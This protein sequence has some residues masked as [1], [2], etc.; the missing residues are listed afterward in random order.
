MQQYLTSHDV[1]NT[2]RMVRTL[3]RGSIV[4]VE[5]DTDLRVYERLVDSGNC[6]LI[7]AFGKHNALAAIRDL[8]VSSFRG[9]AAIVDSDFWLLDSVAPPGNN[10]LVTDS[11][12][13]ESMI[14]SSPA[15]DRVTGELVSRGRFARLGMRIRD[16]L[17]TCALPLGYFR[18]L[19][20]PTK[21][22]VPLRFKEVPPGSFLSRGTL[23]PDVHRMVRVTNANSGRILANEALMSK[24]IAQ[25]VS[26]RA[27]D[28]W[29]V[30]SGHDMVRILSFGL[31]TEF[32]NRRGRAATTDL[33]DAMLRLAYEAS[34][35]ST[36]KL[37]K[38][39]ADWEMA[40]PPFKV[41]P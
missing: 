11:H 20:S 5:G 40:N 24:T 28:P 1:A 9:T 27:H 8:E 26:N 3:H 39:I 37:R 36:T 13:L 17:L 15:L 35:F 14:L 21:G 34:F 4:I 22:N 2:V 38:S 30:C 12:D 31:R 7:P 6:R 29:H 23:R 32:G 10:V 41:L 16:L 25:L 18:W 33:V 19:V